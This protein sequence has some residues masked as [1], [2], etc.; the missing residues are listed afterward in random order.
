MLTKKEYEI[1]ELRVKKGLTQVAIATKLG[2]SQAAVSH[3][4]RSAFKKIQDSKKIIKIANDLKLNVEHE[5]GFK[6]K[7]NQKI[8]KKS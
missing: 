2:I 4:E 8:R 1:L 3:F 6:I 7:E 5:S